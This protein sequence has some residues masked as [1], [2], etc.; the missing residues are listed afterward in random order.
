M[1]QSSDGGR[2][3]WASLA[4]KGSHIRLNKNVMEILLEKDVRGAFSVNESEAARVIQ[5]LGV[6]I[7]SHAE[8]VQICPL[9]RNVIQVTLK[10]NVDMS[11]FINKE[12]FEVKSGVRVSQVRAAGQRVVTLLVKGLHPQTP[13]STVIQ[14]LKCM[15]KVEKTKVILDTY[16]EGPLKGLQNG[17]RRYSVEFLPNINVGAW[18]II[19][20]QKVTFSFPG[21]R[22]S[23]FRC[24]KIASECLGNA[25]AKD[26]EAAGGAR[27]LLVDHMKEFWQLIKYT[28]DAVPAN[29]DLSEED[30]LI[31]HQLG[32]EFTP[33]R[34]LISG[35]AVPAAECGALSVKWFPKRADHGDI[36][37]FLVSHG[38]PKD[39]EDVTIKDNGQVI[40]QNLDSDICKTMCTLI[41]GKKFQGKKNI[42]C[43]GIVLVTPEKHKVTVTPGV[44]PSSALEPVSSISTGMNSSVSKSQKINDPLGDFIFADMSSSKFYKKPDEPDS[45]TDFSEDNLENEVGK[46]ENNVKKRK[47]K[48]TKVDVSSKKHDRRTTPKSKKNH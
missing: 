40:I 35:G 15:A 31:E 8:M 19:D 43:Q 5:K 1:A 4:S 45:E 10:Q 18:H 9:G 30:D 32:G 12:A 21:Q 38:P 13:D 42:Y 29:Q 34:N 27:R 23:C 2:H 36:L 28:P 3:S 14:Y 20:G 22:R 25:I 33:K 17:D 47:Q 24:L 26:C 16:I 6:D 41:T 37:D 44:G 11:K 46:W 39:H 48:N 7:Q